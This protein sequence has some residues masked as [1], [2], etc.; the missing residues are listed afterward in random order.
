MLEQLGDTL[1]VG[2]VSMQTLVLLVV[3][4]DESGGKSP[5]SIYRMFLGA[6]SFAAIDITAAIPGMGCVYRGF[7]TNLVSK[8]M[9]FL[10]LH[11]GMLAMWRYQSG[12]RNPN[13]WKTLKRLVWI[14]KLLLPAVS[15]LI[16]KSF[17]CS[18]YDN[19]DF[20]YLAVDHEISCTS[21]TYAFL[22]TYAALM[23]VAFPIGI[24]LLWLIKLRELRDR[25]NPQDDRTSDTNPP[26]TLPRGRGMSAA[27][28]Q[29]IPRGRGMSAVDEYN[30]RD[31]TRG[32]RLPRKINIE[33]DPVLSVSPMQ[34]SPTD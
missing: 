10:C 1:S 8:T 7:T 23:G 26:Q 14:S 27:T 25:I 20:E 12:K 17:R 31:H 30:D 2:F 34:V 11:V 33:D 5:P 24:P 3:N 13:A 9:L 22:V 28:P 19:G 21:S 4:H 16:S 18:V 15:I 29:A 32:Y 6:F